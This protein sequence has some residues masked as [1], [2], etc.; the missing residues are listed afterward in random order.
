MTTKSGGDG[1][2]DERRWK[3]KL[4]EERKE[5]RKRRYYALPTQPAKELRS[6]TQTQASIPEVSQGHTTSMLRGAAI[7]ET[8]NPNKH[9]YKHTKLWCDL[10]PNS[11]LSGHSF[12]IHGYKEHGAPLLPK[13]SKDSLCQI[14]GVKF[15]S[16]NSLIRHEDS[17]SEGATIAEVLEQ[18][19][20]EPGVVCKN[21]VLET[22]GTPIKCG[23]VT[24]IR[25]GTLFAR[26][27]LGIEV[28]VKFIYGCLQGD[29][30]RRLMIEIKELSK[31]SYT[32]MAKDIMLVLR[33]YVHL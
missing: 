6:R 14:C 28:W 12:M 30:L 23:A 15:S 31:D 13:V 17:H 4:F 10:C 3:E 11:F 19:S 16:Y 25:E 2:E 32:R 18:A 22:C 27:K 1:D 24:S 8:Q 9:E 26:S 29:D 21:L 20:K 33:D 7:F 5:A